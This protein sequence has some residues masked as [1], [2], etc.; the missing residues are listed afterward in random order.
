MGDTVRVKI[1]LPFSTITLEFSG[2]NLKKLLN[3]AKRLGRRPRDIDVSWEEVK[4]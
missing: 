2:A 1:E 4:E 3:T